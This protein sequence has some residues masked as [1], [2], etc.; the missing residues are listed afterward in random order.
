MNCMSINFRGVKFQ[1]YDVKPER[2]EWDNEYE[3]FTEDEKE[4]HWT[5]AWIGRPVF[6]RRARNP[7][8]F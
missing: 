4:D 8:F 7:A 5:W 3:A 6:E 1:S 2:Y